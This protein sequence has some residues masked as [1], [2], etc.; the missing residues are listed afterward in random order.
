MAA[1]TSAAPKGL[2][3]S[4]FSSVL[5]VLS[6][7]SAWPAKCCFSPY[8]PSLVAVALSGARRRRPAESRRHIRSNRPLN[9]LHRC[10]TCSSGRQAR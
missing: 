2:N 3:H 10:E 5:R 8:T 9:P 7:H 6:N 1:A 4:L